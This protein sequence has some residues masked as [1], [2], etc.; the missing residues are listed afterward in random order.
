MPGQPSHRWRGWRPKIL[1]PPQSCFAAPSALA[2][3]LYPPHLTADW[4]LASKA[5]PD[6]TRDTGALFAPPAG[7]IHGLLLHHDA[8]RDRCHVCQ[9]PASSAAARGLPPP[10]EARDPPAPARSV[11]PP[12]VADRLRPARRERLRGTVLARR[13]HMR[14]SLQPPTAHAPALFTARQHA[15]ASERRRRPP[16]REPPQLLRTGLSPLRG[17]LRGAE[18]RRSGGRRR[19][20]SHPRVPPPRAAASRRRARDRHESEGEQPRQPRPA[21]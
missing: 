20:S 4:Q 13:A 19:R 9:S 10:S 17:D 11:E 16:A 12:N 2:R 8:R 18:P 15:E 5:R 14:R 21:G 6:V 3:P 7:L 1:S